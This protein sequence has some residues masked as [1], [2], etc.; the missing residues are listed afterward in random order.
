MPHSMHR[1]TAAYLR[2]QKQAE[3]Q[4]KRRTRALSFFKNGRLVRYV[5]SIWG[6]SKS[7]AG[8]IHSCLKGKDKCN[9]Q[10]LLDPLNNRSGRNTIWA[11]EKST[12]FKRTYSFYVLTS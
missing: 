6:I 5:A 11:K 7:T 3:D 9:L 1:Q 10:K 8:R 12:D 2:R 4:K